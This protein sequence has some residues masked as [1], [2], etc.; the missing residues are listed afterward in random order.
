MYF[1][2]IYGYNFEEIIKVEKVQ[3]L[4]IIDENDSIIASIAFFC[5]LFFG[6]FYFF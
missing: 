6:D 1:Q 3:V 4:I 2:E 5:L